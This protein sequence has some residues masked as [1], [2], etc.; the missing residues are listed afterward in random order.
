MPLGSVAPRLELE[1]FEV[2]LDDPVANSR[3]GWSRR[4]GALLHLRT[5]D[6]C[7][8]G[9]A[10][11]LPGYSPESLADT[12]DVLRAWCPDRRRFQAWKD[13]VDSRRLGD[14]RRLTADLIDEIPRSLPSARFGLETALLDAGGR[15]LGLP[16]PS[17]LVESRPG[18]GPVRQGLL[19]T[20]LKCPQAAE[21]GLSRSDDGSGHVLKVKVGRPEA[22]AELDLLRGLRRRF[23]GLEIRLDANGAWDPAEA[24]QKLDELAG[25]EIRWIEEPVRWGSLEALRAWTARQAAVPTALDE[26]LW[27][28]DL[29][30]E[31]LQSMGPAALILKPQLL[32]GVLACL[33]WADAVPNV[34]AILSHAFDGP[35]AHRAATAAARAL[36]AGLASGHK[37]DAAHG[38]ASHAVLEAWPGR[39][40]MWSDDPA[41]PGLGWAS[42]ADRGPAVGGAT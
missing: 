20:S 14:L 8:L 39:G 10:S 12:L 32:G 41:A 9:E 40:D 17:L 5:A 33:K 34:P 1:L 18:W 16:L 11:P 29:R 13:A 27:R 21:L 15:G 4:R 7:G 3:R 28:L 19:W 37:G 6:L 25:L 23:P 2:E 36:D 24:R 35:V 38:L 31:D 26:S 30:P 22:E 42:A